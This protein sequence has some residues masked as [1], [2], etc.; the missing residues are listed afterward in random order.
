MANVKSIV[1]VMAKIKLTKQG[2]NWQNES[3]KLDTATAS[4]KWHNDQPLTTLDATNRI[5]YRV[6]DLS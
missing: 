1:F 5:T 2:W 3:P 6:P 4:Y